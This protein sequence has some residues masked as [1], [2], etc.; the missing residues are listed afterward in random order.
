MA[1]CALARRLRQGLVAAG[2]ERAVLHRVPWRRGGSAHR[3]R[4][5][6]RLGAGA[7]V[8]RREGSAGGGGGRRGSAGRR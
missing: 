6:R 8:S 4:G 7:G 3:G 5:R 1:A 2:R